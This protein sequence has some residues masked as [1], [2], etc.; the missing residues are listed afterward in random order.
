MSGA[1]PTAE[2]LAKRLGIKVSEIKAVEHTADGPVVTGK[3]DQRLIVLSD[4]TL[5]WY[6]YGEKPPN[7]TIPVFDPASGEVER[8]QPPAKKTA[9][10]K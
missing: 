2:E 4:G 9:S 6:G 10:S 8:P 1:K 3:D 7:Y 5:A